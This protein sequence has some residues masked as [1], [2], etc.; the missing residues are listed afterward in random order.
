MAEHGGELLRRKIKAADGR[1]PDEN[2]IDLADHLAAKMSESLLLEPRFTLSPR[3]FDAEVKSVKAL[4]AD[5]PKKSL[6]CFTQDVLFHFDNKLTYYWI[7]AGLAGEND[8][9]SD[10]DE[11][12]P[13][14]IDTILSRPL[15]ECLFAPLLKI[16]PI[17]SEKT[18]MELFGEMEIER[19]IDNVRFLDETTKIV[20]ISFAFGETEDDRA[21]ARLVLPVSVVEEITVSAKPRELEDA[22]AHGV[23]T[24]HMHQETLELPLALS[25]VINQTSMTID[26]ISKFEPGQLIVFPRDHLERIHLAVENGSDVR[27][28][29][30]GQL[31]RHQSQKAVKLLEDPDP[32]FADL[33]TENI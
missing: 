4:F 5:L 6:Y 28:L 19:L 25:A 10:E 2:V 17:L 16:L 31:G 18:E 23:W 22:S 32:G 11:Y 30:V 9:V 29:A 27:P 3:Y 7:E 33:L 15:F 26:E 20:L 8:T 1:K 12:V 13:T 14:A 21:I 24:S